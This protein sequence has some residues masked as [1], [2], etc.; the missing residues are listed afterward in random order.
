MGRMVSLRPSLWL[1]GRAAMRAAMAAMM[2]C[3]WLVVVR[4]G[5]WRL[6][7]EVYS[8]ISLPFLVDSTIDRDGPGE[9]FSIEGRS[10]LEEDLYS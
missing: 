10:E 6:T 2:F 9:P 4:L 3:H 5:W 1:G 8:T 7:P